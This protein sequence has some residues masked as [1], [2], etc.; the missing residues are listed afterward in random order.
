MFFLPHLISLSTGLIHCSWTSEQHAFNTY[1]FQCMAWTLSNSLMQL[2]IESKGHESSVLCLTCIVKVFCPIHNLL[3]MISLIKHKHTHPKCSSSVLWQR[4]TTERIF[5]CWKQTCHEDN[6]MSLPPCP[7]CTMT[8]RFINMT[9]SYLQYE[10][11]L[12][13]VA[14]IYNTAKTKYCNRTIYI[15]FVQMVTTTWQLTKN[16]FWIQQASSWN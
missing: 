16:S 4:D 14:H 1:V 3:Y 13:A 10:K 2:L 11:C 9:Q 6:T 8:V 5:G 15:L 12:N 7:P